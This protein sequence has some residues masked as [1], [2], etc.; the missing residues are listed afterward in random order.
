MSAAESQG[1]AS[2]LLWAD[3]RFDVPESAVALSD[4]LIRGEGIGWLSLGVSPGAEVG[5][6]LALALPDLNQ[7]RAERLLTDVA[8]AYQTDG[9]VIALRT[10]TVAIDDGAIT[11]QPIRILA[12]SRWVLS[13]LEQQPGEV[14]KAA[15]LERVRADGDGDGLMLAQRIVRAIAES[16]AQEVESCID[17]AEASAED[18]ADEIVVSQLLRLEEVCARLRRRSVPSARAWFS[19]EGAPEIALL[20]D[21]ALESA[22]GARRGVRERAAQRQVERQRGQN[23]AFHLLL[24]FVAAVFVGPGLVASALDAFPGW[25]PVDQRDDAFVGLSIVSSGLILALTY[26]M[27]AV[28]TRS[29]GGRVAASLAGA[30]LALCVGL[31]ILPPLGGGQDDTP[32]TVNVEC[33]VSPV[34]QGSA[35]AMLIAAADDRGLSRDPSGER[36]VDTASVGLTRE[37]VVAE[38]RHGR[39]SVAA[40]VFRVVAPALP[41]RTPSARRGAAEG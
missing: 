28:L 40:C 20:L 34:V 39:R 41:E 23:Q 18:S 13:L 30:V 1:Q 4:A 25:L 17:R 5:E 7:S 31:A 21:E 24:G 35:V 27:P 29:S 10:A 8:P 9:P 33:P 6:V 3:G 32:P 22:R 16:L 14:G 38:D 15:V 26:G 37:V 36:R 11:S 2:R 12:T 19:E